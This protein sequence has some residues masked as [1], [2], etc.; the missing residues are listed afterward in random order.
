MPGGP[1]GS[2]VQMQGYL[3]R[4]SMGFWSRRRCVLKENVFFMF[5]DNLEE[6]AVDIDSSTRISLF[7]QSGPRFAIETQGGGELH[8]RASDPENAV[9]WVL[10]L[11]ACG[12]AHPELSIDS[13][14]RISVI[15]Q[16]FYGKV[17]LARK[18]DSGEL[19][20]I[21]SIPKHRLVQANKVHTVLTERD[22]LAQASHPFIVPLYYAFQTKS[23]FYLC[24]EYVHGGEL[25]Q[26]MRTAVSA[27]DMRL[28]IAEISLALR[29]LHSLGIIYRDLKPENV[30]LDRDGHVKLTD[31]GLSKHLNSDVN[32]STFC[33]TREYLAPEIVSGK[34]YSIGV[35]WWAVGILLYEMF[36]GRTPF[37]CESAAKL[38]SRIARAEIPFPRDIDPIGQSLIIGLLEKDPARRFG[39]EQLRRHE[40]FNGFDFDDILE[41]KVHPDFVPPIS[42]IEFQNDGPNEMGTLSGSLDCPVVGSAAQVKGFSF[43]MRGTDTSIGGPFPY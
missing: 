4:R 41:K 20:A 25:F 24:L 5:K 8:L 26:R 11:R 31:F 22:I 42:D 2:I 14:H 10:A 27:S 43:D 18:I 37:V 36:Y 21:K 17:S 19:F 6:A 1:D 40:F 29:H 33:G 32:T 39:F 34:A 30:L 15:G 16:G 12:F 23:R 28:Y 13:F 35:D 7:E 38:F 9:A 3:D